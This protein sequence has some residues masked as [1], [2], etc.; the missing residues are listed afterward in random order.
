MD[1]RS[2]G[3][4]KWTFEYLPERRGI[5]IIG[6]F[7]DE[8]GNENIIRQFLP[9]HAVEGLMKFYQSEIEKLEKKP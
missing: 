2:Y 5:N 4:A 3:I 9:L 7:H 1:Y 8:D 6:V